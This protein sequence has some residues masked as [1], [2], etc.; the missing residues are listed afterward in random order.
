MSTVALRLADAATPAVEPKAKR[1]LF[2][3]LITAR[4]SEA[5]RRIQT[6]LATQSDRRLMDLG[7]S[8]EDIKTL[9]QGRLPAR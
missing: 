3:R 4:E 2:Q 6:Y 9:R 8:A 1:G 5:I 7:Y